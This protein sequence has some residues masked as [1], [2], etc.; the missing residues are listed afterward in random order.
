MSLN[1]TGKDICSVWIYILQSCKETFFGG[2]SF[3]ILQKSLKWLTGVS[4]KN[5]RS[6]KKTACERLM[7]LDPRLTFLINVAGS[8]HDSSLKK[9]NPNHRSYWVDLGSEMYSSMSYFGNGPRFDPDL[10]F[11]PS[12]ILLFGDACSW[13]VIDWLW[14]TWKIP[15]QATEKPCTQWPNVV[16]VGEVGAM[17]IDCLLSHLPMTFLLRS[18]MN[19]PKKWDWSIGP[20][21]FR[22]QCPR[23]IHP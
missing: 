13:W 15:F 4:S 1:P 22:N 5:G 18:S 6:Q 20:K 10:N 19:P 21:I 2:L 7:C 16:N 8:C 17:M 23:S 9:P 11:Q 3:W 12:M 14:L